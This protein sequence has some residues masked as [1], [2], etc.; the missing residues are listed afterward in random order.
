MPRILVLCYSMYGHIETMAADKAKQAGAELEQ[1]APVADPA[2]LADYDA[3]VFG[4]PTRFGGMTGQMRTF[5]DQTGALWAHGA[6]LGK[7]AS[8]STSSANQRGGQE[9]T[10]LSFHTILLHQGMIVLGLPYSCQDQT[11]MEEIAG[12]ALSAV[13]K[14]GTPP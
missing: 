2:E 14:R 7:V 12:G 6:L 13:P 9:S 1:A 10:P 5:L 11:T 3:I 4:T 8:V